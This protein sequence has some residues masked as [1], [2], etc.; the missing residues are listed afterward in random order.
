MRA[1]LYT[2]YMIHITR[3]MYHIHACVVSLRLTR[4]PPRNFARSL[5]WTGSGCTPRSSRQPQTSTGTSATFCRWRRSL[6]L[7]W[8]SSRFRARES[9]TRAWCQKAQSTQRSR[10]RSRRSTRLSRRRRRPCF[11]IEWR[12]SRRRRRGGGVE[13]SCCSALVL[14]RTLRHD[15]RRDHRRD[16]RHCCNGL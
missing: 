8:K 11:T 2:P 10:L 1:C 13:R 5:W 3:L 16:R 6:P 12:R 15:L 9:H 14:S 4:Q 7:R